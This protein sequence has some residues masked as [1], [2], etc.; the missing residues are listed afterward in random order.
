MHPVLLLH[1]LHMQLEWRMRWK[2]WKQSKKQRKSCS[3]NKKKMKW[4]LNENSE[5]KK[6]RTLAF[7]S[8]PQCWLF[9]SV[10]YLISP[11][12]PRVAFNL[13]NAVKGLFVFLSRFWYIIYFLFF[14]DSPH[15]FPPN[16]LWLEFVLHNQMEWWEGKKTSQRVLYLVFEWRE[17]ENISRAKNVK[18]NN[19]SQKERS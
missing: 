6:E 14:C 15:F 1:C 2:E 9:V 16:W 10:W 5:R 13:F 12:T 8:I 18:R 17:R 19:L 7:Y 11:R 4:K 3:D